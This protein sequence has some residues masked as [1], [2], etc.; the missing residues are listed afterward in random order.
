MKKMVEGECRNEKERDINVEKLW[1]SKAFPAWGQLTCCPS[2]ARL[3]WVTLK[4][5]AMPQQSVCASLVTME[6]KS[7]ISLFFCRLLS[8]C[9]STIRLTLCIA[10]QVSYILSHNLFSCLIQRTTR[11][12]QYFNSGKPLGQQRFSSVPYRKSLHSAII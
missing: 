12:A 3:V 4:I 8:F 1:S 2:W 6:E 9:P 10:L 11:P 7:T 5:T